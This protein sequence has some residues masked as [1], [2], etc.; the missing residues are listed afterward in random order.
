MVRDQYLC[1]KLTVRAVMEGH[2]ATL[3]RIFDIEGYVR[4]HDGGAVVIRK[5]TLFPKYIYADIDREVYTTKQLQ[6]TVRTLQLRRPG[7]PISNSFLL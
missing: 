7:V 5:L 3:Q 2:G 1:I 4:R 6:C